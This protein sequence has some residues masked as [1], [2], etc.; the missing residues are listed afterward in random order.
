ME[1]VFML[2]IETQN[3]VGFEKVRSWIDQS[4]E[5]KVETHVFLAAHAGSFSGLDSIE[6]T[7]FVK[8]T[9]SLSYQELTGYLQVPNASAKSIRIT[10]ASK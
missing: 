6:G 5:S 8:N 9:V 1:Q 2:E 4:L 10:T 3:K 7:L